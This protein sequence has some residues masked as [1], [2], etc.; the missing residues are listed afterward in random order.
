MLNGSDPQRNCAAK[1]R[2]NT[3]RLL[4]LLLL[5]GLSPQVTAQNPLPPRGA[6]RSPDCL[7]RASRAT[8]HCDPIEVVVHTEKEVTFSLEIPSP[9]TVHCA[10]ITEIEYTQRDTIV[11]VE[12]RIVNTDCAASKGEYRLTVR[13][14][15]ENRELKTLEFLES[16]Q[17]QDDQPVQFKGDYPIGENA[18]V[19]SVRPSQLACACTETPTE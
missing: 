10:A 13:I 1:R 17:R 16:W 9:K 3:V 4:V 12:G 2:L 11:S 6:E 14:R 7:P 18:D 8:I 15:D 19:V 5:P